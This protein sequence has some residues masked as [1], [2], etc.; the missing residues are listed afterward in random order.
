MIRR[1]RAIP[2]R[3]R[4]TVGLIAVLVGLVGV[5]ALSTAGSASFVRPDGKLAAAA[6]LADP[7]GVSF[8]LEGCRNDGSIALPNG[9]GD[10]ICDDSVYTTGNLGKGWNELD[11]VPFRLTSDAGNSAPASQTFTV[12]VVLDNMDGGNPGYDVLSTLTLNTSLSDAGCTAP[13]IGPQQ[14]TTG[15]GGIDQSLYRLV[16]ITQ[17]KNTTCIY[18]YY[19]RLAL[20][21]NLFPG[22]S[23]HA[24]L[25]NGI[26]SSAGIG[27]K[28]V[29]IPVNEIAPQELTKDMSATQ[30]SDHVWDI[31]KEP[32]PA[33][34]SFADTCD[35]TSGANS[36]GVQIKIT[37]TK[38]DASPSGDITV[39][40]H[41]YATN[42]AARVITVSLSDV[43]YSGTTALH[44]TPAATTDVPA[45]TQLLV[46]THSTTVPSG[47]SDLNDIATAS[48]TDKVT[49]VP[50]P[51]TTTATASANVQLSGPELNQSAVID[52]VESITPSPPFKFSADSFDPSGSGAFNGYTAG[53]KTAG[54]VEWISN[55][56]GDSGSVTL[57]KTIYV[58]AGSAANSGTLDDTAT[59]TGADGFTTD[60]DASVD[61]SSNKYVTLKISKSIPNVLSGSDPAQTFE[62]KVYDSSNN[63]VDTETLTFNAGDTSK[64][65]DVSGLLPDTY[66]VKET[67][68]SGWAPQSDQ[69]VDLS[70]ACS[71]TASFANKL[72]PA[73]AKVVKTTTPSG[74][75]SGWSMTLKKDGTAIETLS[76]NSSGVAQFV[77]VLEE[78]HTYSIEETVKS[79]WFQ[80]TT[81]NCSGITVNYPADGGKTF[82]CS[83]ENIQY[84]SITVKKV[85]EP[86]GD[87]TKFTF[88]GDLAG[89]I[90]D[91]QQI[92]PTQEK[93]GTY[94]TTETVPS[95]WDL[96]SIVCN[97]SDSSGSGATATFK[98]AAGE[99]VTCTYTDTKRGQAKVVKTVLGQAPSGV[100]SFTFQ[101]RTGASAAAAG[102]ILETGTANAGNGGVITF[103][104]KLVP[105]TTYQLCEQMSPGWTT[106][107]G[108]PLYSVYNPSGDNSVV[109]TDF[110]VTAGQLKT[111]AIDNK[112]PPGGMALTIGYWKN[113]SSCTGG[114]QKP[115]LDAT[116]LKMSNAGTPE[117]LGNLVIDPKVL[118]ATKACQYAANILSK[119]TLTGKK[120]SSDPLFNMA[121]QLL[122]A[123]LNLGAGAGQCAAS[124]TAINQA[125]ALL[126]TYKFDGNGYTPK[127]STADANLANSLGTTLDKY[128]NNKLC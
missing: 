77:S 112:P 68:L 46:L 101:L 50:V 16:T 42:P 96:K 85:T 98:V 36:A 79:G 8:T 57:D 110:T 17:A 13:T 15:F 27:G 7:S 95:G 32:T 24:N 67:T 45:N 62:F 114:G 54:P 28:E 52:D 89:S 80:N 88:T 26:P 47:T 69:N 37:W 22:A 56:Q 84:G 44:S 6:A 21:S 83:I 115:T 11:L 122:A 97:D 4:L 41:V 2:P 127:L 109:C 55:S 119:Q 43:I 75:E 113:W 12:A 49:G 33:K 91:G 60:T 120:M 64:S 20:G 18:D 23:L 63:L 29:S 93:P 108:P 74:N 126:S 117:T 40:T 116:L 107:L 82:T 118:G 19:G 3:R 92:G 48:Y 35:N 71:G 51:G 99:N 10:F 59:L 123:D 124:A 25:A 1:Y 128:N 61:V 76:T 104:T 86:S 31:K 94:S 58:N 72:A 100:Q 66:T 81:S 39:I 9:N 38:E 87:T 14:T 103:S 73:L 90:G 111:F 125:H 30:G 102:T 78:G 70:S 65:V 34:V 106:T 53:T 121:A 5:L 105:G